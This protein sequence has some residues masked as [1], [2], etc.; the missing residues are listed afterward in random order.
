MDPEEVTV[1]GCRKGH[2]P[3]VMYMGIIMHLATR[4]LKCQ[5]FF[6]DWSVPF[7]SILAGCVQSVAWSR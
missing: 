4:V 5:G 6:S 7:K 1:I 2:S 3:T